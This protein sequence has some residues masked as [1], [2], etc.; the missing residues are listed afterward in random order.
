[1]K[2]GITVETVRGSIM[3]EERG[4]KCA[5]RGPQTGNEQPQEE[6]GTRTYACQTW[7]DV[8]VI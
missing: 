1:M 6:E 8:C 5:R 2:A 3:V 7:V 4:Q